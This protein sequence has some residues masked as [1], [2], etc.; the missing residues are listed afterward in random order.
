MSANRT[1]FIATLSL[2]VLLCIFACIGMAEISQK[3][4]EGQA[5]LRRL[6]VMIEESQREELFAQLRKFADKHGFE[7]RI[8]K[9][10]PTREGFFIQMFR[11]DLYIDGTVTRFDPK[12]VSIGVFDENPVHPTSEEIV[13]ELFSDLKI[14]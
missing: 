11:D 10:G 1:K 6:R 13:D 12:I 4:S 14:S 9:A 5:P 7:I 2:G 3:G 8:R